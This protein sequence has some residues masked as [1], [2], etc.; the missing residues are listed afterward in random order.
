[1]AVDVGYPDMMGESNVF[2]VLK[3][4]AIVFFL[5]SDYSSSTSAAVQLPVYK[6]DTVRMRSVPYLALLNASQRTFESSL[7]DSFD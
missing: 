1:M 7:F 3:L 5:A 6:Y 4:R 2:G